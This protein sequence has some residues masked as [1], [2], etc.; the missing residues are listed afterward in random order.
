MYTEFSTFR[1]TLTHS[2]THS[3][4]FP[5]HPFP[6]SAPPLPHLPVPFL[7]N[8]LLILSIYI[9]IPQPSHHPLHE[10][11]STLILVWSGIQKSSPATAMVD[12]LSGS[13]LVRGRTQQEQESQRAFAP[14]QTL[15]LIWPFPLCMTPTKELTYAACALPRDG[16]RPT[17]LFI[18]MIVSKLVLF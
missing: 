15:G 5:I 6:C 7:T 10:W 14:R 1:P 18:W 16:Q 8:L 4:H 11:L 3:P 9:S 2:P 17:L 12:T 13:S